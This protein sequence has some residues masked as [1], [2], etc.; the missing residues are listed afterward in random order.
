MKGPGTSTSV[1]SN[2][3]AALEIVQQVGKIVKSV[4]FLEPIGA[5]LSQVRRG[6]QGLVV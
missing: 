1:V 5:I 6:L 2:L 3:S 4:P